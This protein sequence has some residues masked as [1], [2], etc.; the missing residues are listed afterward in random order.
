M[1]ILGFNSIQAYVD[2]VEGLMTICCSCREKIR[3]DKEWT[4][5]AK[6][7]VIEM[8]K[9]GRVS[10]TYCLDC[11]EVRMASIKKEQLLRSKK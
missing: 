10:H 1:K 11:F 5:I 9:T 4:T 7:V 8:E 6:E 3:I 2:S